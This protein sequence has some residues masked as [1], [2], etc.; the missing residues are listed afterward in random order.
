VSIS[1]TFIDRPIAT[2]LLMAAI[3]L[4][5]ILAYQKLPVAPLPRVD[6]PTIQVG[7]TL[8][9]ADPETMASSVATPLER[10]F[11]QIS[12]LT[13][14]TSSSVL[15]NTQVNL[16]F[17]LD[18]NIDGAAQDV[19]AAISAAGG[20]LPKNLPNPPVWKKQNP[21][22]KPILMFG[23]TSD[24]LPVDQLDDIADTKLAQQLSQIPGV[25]QVAIYGEQKP[26]V[27]VQINPVKIANQ[28][29]SLEDVRNVLGAATV[30]GPKGWFDGKYQ[31]STISANDQILN[32]DGYKRL[33]IAYRNGAPV[34]I[35]DVGTAIDAVENTEVAAWANQ[36]PG[37]VLPVFK[38]PDANI[39]E[40]TDLVKSELARLSAFLP[41]SAKLVILN[42][43]TK[44][45]R[46]SVKDVQQTL[47]ITIALVIMVIFLFLRK[48]WATL[49]PAL[50]VPL[51]LVGT[52]GVMYMM[53]YSLD[54]LSL[55]A[56]TIAVG[57]VVDDA[58]VMIE[59]IVR[60]IEA[61]DN[62]YD[63]A[64]KGASEIGFTIISIS[65]SLI[66]VFIPLLLMGGVVGRLLHEFAMTVA[67]A[68]VISAFVSLTLTPTMC[69]RFLG[70]H[71][72]HEGKFYT[73]L[74]RFFDWTVDGYARLLRIVL[75]HQ[76]ITLLSFAATVA[77]TVLLFV[78]IPKGFFPQQDTGLI[79]I[80]TEGSLDISFAEMKRKQVEA[81]G[82]V[83]ADPAVS[84]LVSFAGA[85]GGNTANTGRMFAELTPAD[86]RPG[87]TA[88]DVINRLRPKLAQMMGFRTFMQ[89]P[90][91]INVGARGARTQYQYTL[92]D[93]D[94]DELNHWANVMFDR[95]KT[96]PQLQDVAT[97]QQDSASKIAIKI[98]RDRASRLGVTAQAIDD[99]LYDAFGERQVATMFTQLN[100]YHVVLEVDPKFQQDPASL[101]QIYVKST[102]GA[103]VPLS[104]F[105]SFESAS[106]ALSINHQ[107]QFPATT[108]SFNLPP[109]VALGD[110]TN[111]IKIAEN[112]VHM[113]ATISATFQGNAQ[114]FKDS[115]SSVPLLI[116]AA[117]VT[118]Y[119]VLGILYESFIHP[120][121]ILSTLPSAGVG[122]LI[123]LWLFNYPLDIVALIGIILLIGIVKKNAIMMIDFAL[124]AERHRNMPPH[125]AIYQAALLRFR[126]IMMT[127][128]CALFSGIP[129]MIASGAGS[130]LRRPLGFAIVGGLI[131]SQALTLFTTPVIYLYL[132]RL[133]AWVRGDRKPPGNDAAAQ[134]EK[135][136]P[137]K[138]MPGAAA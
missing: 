125:E 132:D 103:Q 51:S 26:A 5:G 56:M 10:Q 97:D 104:A 48:L 115:L 126:P 131:L 106:S 54:N 121:T 78:N 133:G 19:Q 124:E 16:Q 37:I 85:G 80:S 33:I 112:E 52:F 2:A 32:A 6:F 120:L 13:Q 92:Q 74:E 15:G 122:A 99:T 22:D 108:I 82:I 43:R 107:G 47:I 75:R 50:A 44:T 39:I 117:L 57:F 67:I 96:I 101:Q 119:I 79:Q 68:V 40:T 63:A 42:D 12:G 127:T 129:L 72:E 59:N 98:D 128:M 134:D 21:A 91:E 114:A 137:I 53:G 14:M 130:E 34:R 138:L 1:K 73:A 100:Q 61:G 20:Q 83:L 23:L 110:A 28:G 102:T 27:R 18:R 46:A 64:V 17:D 90:Q 94:I 89:S 62:A 70:K 116:V 136:Q 93:P 109:N 29:L 11:A 45:I 41:P 7:A 84:S 58:I 87:V 55:M 123:M 95:L 111:Q 86:T 4:A 49:I 81:A 30:N 3:M 76:R 9:G 25:S 105:T 113:P 71:E 24:V 65:V 66:A 35:S 60:Y 77:V 36:T 8:P 31:A 135:A 88:D 38:Q 69:A 118:V